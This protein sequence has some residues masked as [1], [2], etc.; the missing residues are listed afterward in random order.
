LTF[1]LNGYSKIETSCQ[2]ML[3]PQIKTLVIY[4]QSFLVYFGAGT[5]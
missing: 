4:K 5:H 1:T 2:I 3:L